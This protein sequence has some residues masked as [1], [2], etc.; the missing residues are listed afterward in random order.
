VLNREDAVANYIDGFVLPL[1]RDRLQIYKEVAKK[2][3]EI[4]KEYGALE[5]VEY[6]SDDADLEGTR[7]FSDAANAKE[8][9]TV[10]FGWVAFASR[11]ARDL[12]NEKVA[13]DPRMAELVSPLITKSKPIF[14]GKRMVYGGFRPLV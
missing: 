5:Y 13:S 11:E 10:I 7:S 2:V 1:P 9:E 3:A 4:W 8:D 6:V 12:A 14:D